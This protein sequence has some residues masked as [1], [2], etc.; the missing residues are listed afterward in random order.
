MSIRLSASIGL[1]CDAIGFEDLYMSRLGFDLLAF[2]LAGGSFFQQPL[3]SF[4]T[5]IS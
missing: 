2:Y 5:L 4:Q 3:R 1:V